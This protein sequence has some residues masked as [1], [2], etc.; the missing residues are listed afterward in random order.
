MGKQRAYD[1]T[2]GLRIEETVG[3]EPVDGVEAVSV[4]EGPNYGRND[5]NRSYYRLDEG[6]IT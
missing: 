5:C 4:D 2:T 6:A 1:S 3:V